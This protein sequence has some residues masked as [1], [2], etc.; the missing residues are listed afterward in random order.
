MAN[1]KSPSDYEYVTFRAP[2]GLRAKY[3]EVVRKRRE[4]DLSSALRLHMRETVAAESDK[5]AA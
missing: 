2:K 5:E 4:Q 3:R 1:R